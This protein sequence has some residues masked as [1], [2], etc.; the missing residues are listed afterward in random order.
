MSV[1]AEITFTNKQETR[2]IVTETVDDARESVCSTMGPDG[3]YVVIN[4]VGEPNVTKDGASVIKALDFNEPRRN[5]VASIIK[6]AAVRTDKLVGDGTT[7]TVFLIYHLYNEFK[8]LMTFRNIR[9][10]D[11]L[12][13][14]AAD[15]LTNSL[16]IVNVDDPE[17]RKMLMTTANYEE[18]IVN[19]IMDIFQT[20]KDPNITLKLMPNL[21]EDE[22]EK[23]TQILFEGE[24]G[25]P[26]QIPNNE[27]EGYVFKA[28]MARAIF[29]DGMVT[30]LPDGLISMI[31]GITGDEQVVIFAR[32]FDPTALKHINSENSAQNR[33]KYIPYRLT[34][35]GTLGSNIFDDVSKMIGGVP[36]FEMRELKESDIWENRG[37]F[38]IT[39]KGL[40]MTDADEYVHGV[41]TEIL[42]GLDARYSKMSVIDRQTVIGKDLFRRI[43]RLRANNITLKVTG[44][45][46]GNAT[47]RLARYEDVMKAAK[48][49]LHYG[50]IPG[51]GYG[52]LS[53]ID[54]LTILDPYSEPKY[55]GDEK[56]LVG[57]FCNVMKAQYEHLTGNKFVQ[58]EK[59]EFVD[60][61]TG[62]VS[63][64]PEEV[65]DNGWATVIALTGAWS[66]TKTLAKIN[67]LMGRSNKSYKA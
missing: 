42:E 56:E 50:V 15:H 65:Y 39:P 38:M 66:T 45:T 67:N 21:L 49:G 41:A 57:K 9:F 58:E 55:K 17:F 23:T 1:L 4:E 12:V 35:G 46:K 25:L 8:D 14:Q 16:K 3:K 52:Y 27:I 18:D 48:T 2:S 63:E 62:K 53:V 6:D 30:E 13:K 64:I 61:V 26:T 19:K 44:I 51:I 11:Q 7:T 34:A 36:T 31:N 37:A 33:L 43:S 32:S 54:V 60:L 59:P 22:V 40:I 47:E 10:I 28:G 24:F 20:Y 5:L 29:V